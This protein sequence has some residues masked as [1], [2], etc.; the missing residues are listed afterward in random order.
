MRFACDWLSTWLIE[1]DW[2][3]R[4]WSHIGLRNV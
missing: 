4:G 2:E 3:Q 1:S